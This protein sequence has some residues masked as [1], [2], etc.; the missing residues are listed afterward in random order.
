MS[1]I[2]RSF[3]EKD[4]SILVK[5]LNE[6]YADS[7][8]FKPYSENKLRSWLEEGTLKIMIAEE[9][10][11][12]IGSSAYH[13]G[14]W[15]EEIEWLTVLDNPDRES[16][17]NALVREAEKFVKKGTVFTA[18]DAGSSKIEEWTQR[19]YRQ[20]GGLYHMVARLDGLKPIPEAPEGIVLRSLR[21]EEEK[22][23]VD[24]VN[25]GFGTER[26]KMGDIQI[27]K[28]ESP[29]FNEEWVHVAEAEGRIVSA[30]VGKPDTI[31]NRFFNAHRGYLGPAATLPEY[32]SK[33][34]A[35]ML[36]TRAMNFLFEKGMNSVALY[37]SEANVPS[38]TLLRK[39]G[40]EIGHN[41]KFMRRNFKN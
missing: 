11:E 20:E 26:V 10:G 21:L 6:A 4:L 30:V 37:T 28:A 19:G 33:N 32:R 27:W 7:Y 31:Y 24:S 40:L 18:V 1:A 16:I 14:H 12:A 25:A 36:T 41:W 34:L 2:I 29:L 17:E 15:G 22:E 13:D 38:T 39:I 9:N 5:M 23:F 8:E 3:A 35:S